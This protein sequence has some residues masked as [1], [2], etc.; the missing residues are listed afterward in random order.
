MELF[1]GFCVAGKLPC[2]LFLGFDE[3]FQVVVGGIGTA[4]AV[5]FEI[6]AKFFGGA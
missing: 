6:V 5:Q 4:V 2:D 1:W 3:R